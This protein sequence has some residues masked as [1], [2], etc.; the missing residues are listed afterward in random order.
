MCRKCRDTYYVYTLRV[1]DYLF[2]TYLERMR[3]KFNGV[4]IPYKKSAV[5]H[6]CL[7]HLSLEPKE[8][9]CGEVGRFVAF[10]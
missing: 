2:F 8:R 9:E 3:I 10:Y 7:S 5:F 1:H 6:N 4:N